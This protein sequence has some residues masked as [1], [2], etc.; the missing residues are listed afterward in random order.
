LTADPLQWLLGLELLGMKFGLENMHRLVA[1]LD[2]PERHFKSI[3][4]AGT[5]GKGS[6]TAMVAHALHA[7]GYASARYTSPHLERLE[8]R[9]VIRG[10]PVDTATLRETVGTV[11]HAVETIQLQDAEFSPTFFECATAAAFALFRRLRVEIAVV[12]VGLGGRLDATN[13]IDPVVTAI[14]SIDYDHEAL[15]GTTLQAITGEKAGIIKQ[16]VPVVIGRLAPESE[17]VVIETAAGQQ[18]PVTVAAAIPATWENVRPALKGAHQRANVAVAI[19]V[20]ERLRELGLPVPESAIRA[21]VEEVSWPGRLEHVEHEGGS[22]LL[23]AAHNPAGAQ[24]L[25]SYLSEIEWSDAALV[26]GAMHDKKVI[27]MLGYLLPV[28]SSIVCTAAPTPRTESPER[29]ATI[30][31]ELSSVPVHVEPDPVRALA[32]ARRL[33]PRVVIAGS[34]FLLGAVRGILR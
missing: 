22:Y 34:I 5:N 2:H 31:K 18:A 26:F 9:Y 27:G 7:A 15:L 4:I 33:S 25:A 1:Q 19:A 12:E 13:V 16:R 14:T 30:A 3:H 20:L 29:L 6:V 28:V 8:E 21:G 10:Q 23:D 11:R 24:A 17:A 32:L